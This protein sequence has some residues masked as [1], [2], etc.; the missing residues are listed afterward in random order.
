MSNKRIVVVDVEPLKKALKILKDCAGRSPLLAI[1]EYIGLELSDGV[2]RFKVNG[3][4]K[5][6]AIY[7]AELPSETNYNKEDCAVRL[8]KFT[9][10]INKTK[11]AEI[12]IQFYDSYIKVSDFADS[13]KFP[14][15]QDGNGFVTVDVVSRETFG[16]SAFESMAITANMLF[17]KLDT[18]LPRNAELAQINCI[19]FD[20]QTQSMYATNTDIIAQLHPPETISIRDFSIISTRAIQIAS[21]MSPETIIYCDTDID[22]LYDEFLN[23]EVSVVSTPSRYKAAYPTA[24]LV[25]ILETSPDYSFEIELPELVSM[26]EK[27]EIFVD[28][29]T[30]NRAFGSLSNDGTLTFTDGFS[31]IFL[32]REVEFPEFNDFEI[33]K[34]AFNIK[35]LKTVA[36]KFTSPIIDIGL[37]TN[38]IS[39]SEEGLRYVVSTSAL[40]EVQKDVTIWREEK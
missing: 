15:T 2:L 1:S 27:L 36:A 19:C 23:I 21:L 30:T 6:H 26:L 17:K 13:F 18:A 29:K 25:Q 11:S 16:R 40:N 39:L 33:V 37:T 35:T 10:L 34:F 24:Q 12:T 31:K 22:T 5:V 28:T 9:E 4:D 8:D 32:T 20:A 38:T 3:D 14:Y 7:S